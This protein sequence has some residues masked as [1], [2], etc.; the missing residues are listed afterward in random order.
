[1]PAS[2]LLWACMVLLLG[3]AAGFREVQLGVG[4][5]DGLLLATRDDGLVAC[6]ACAQMASLLLAHACVGWISFS[7]AGWWLLARMDSLQHAPRGWIACLLLETCVLGVGGGGG[8]GWGGALGV[9]AVNEDGGIEIGVEEDDVGSSDS[10]LG[11][12]ITFHSLFSWSEKIL[13]RLIFIQ[14]DGVVIFRVN[15]TFY[16]LV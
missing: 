14:T 4:N 8:A 13:E 12:A 7:P 3:P 5:T 1:M 6:D 9:G 10:K 2:Y 16:L 11:K 15:S